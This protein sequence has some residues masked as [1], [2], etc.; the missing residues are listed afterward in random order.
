MLS[1]DD[2]ITGKTVIDVSAIHVD[3]ELFATLY[4]VD[5]RKGE[6]RKIQRHMGE[7]FYVYQ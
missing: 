2:Q 6:K 1:E 4:G 7:P 5:L 3:P